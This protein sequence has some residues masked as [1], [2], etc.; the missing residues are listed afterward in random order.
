MP[1]PRCFSNSGIAP[2]GFPLGQGEESGI[3]YIPDRHP[4]PAD[5]RPVIDTVSLHKEWK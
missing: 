2:K 3:R 1:V 4:N 5:N